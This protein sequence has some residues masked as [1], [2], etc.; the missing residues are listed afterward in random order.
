MKKRI[1]SVLLVLALCLTLLPTAALAADGNHTV[2]DHTKFTKLWM[3]DGNTLMK[4]N[5]PWTAKPIE[6][7][8]SRD[9]D[10]ETA[11]ALTEGTY[12]LGS[13]IEITQHP[14]MITGDVT[15]CLNGKQI[16]CGSPAPD[17]VIGVYANT[18]SELTLTDCGGTGQIA[19]GK[20]YGVKVYKGYTLNMHGGTI[21]GNGAGVEVNGSEG[22]T[23]K[24]NMYGG[25]IS[26]N[27]GTGVRLTQYCTF[28]MSGGTISNNK[29]GVSTG[30]GEFTM[31]GGEISGNTATSNGGGVNIGN[32]GTFTMNAGAKITQNTAGYAGGGVYVSGGTFIMNGGEIK[33][34]IAN[35]AGGGVC[36]E[37]GTFTVSGT[38]TVSE[39]TSGSVGNKVTGNVYLCANKTITINSGLTN[40]T[41]IGVTTGSAKAPTE[42]STIAITTPTS[43]AHGYLSY[44][45]S[46]NDSYEIVANKRNWC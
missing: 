13:D 36:V 12:Y 40:G 14:I 39:N 33:S 1:T 45:K 22:K 20:N 24:L 8:G 32:G 9:E 46:D 43:N 30:G 3:K 38:P 25:A 35:T 44:F 37:N 7:W 5:D 15:L 16:T 34:N 28:T 26:N 17:C 2:D 10:K 31:S 11:Y 23:T 18:A 21:T 4:G 27:T 29:G 41:N 6:V 42:D 19:G